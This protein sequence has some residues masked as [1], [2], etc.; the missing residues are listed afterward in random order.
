MEL[1]IL[2]NLLLKEQ[3]DAGMRIETALGDR[4]CLMHK[5]EIVKIISP[6][7]TIDNLWN[8]AHQHLEEHKSG[9]EIVEFG[10]EEHDRQSKTMPAGVR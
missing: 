10:T 7:T 9:V 6:N 8:L 1:P 5:D 3:R 4:I 2:T